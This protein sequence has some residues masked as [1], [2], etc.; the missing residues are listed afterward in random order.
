MTHEGGRVD[1]EGVL[2]GS[3]GVFLF[4]GMCLP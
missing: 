4:V 3:I 1:S 2:S